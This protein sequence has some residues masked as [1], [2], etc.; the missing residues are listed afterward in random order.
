ME[1]LSCQSVVLTTNAAPMNELIKKEYGFFVEP[2]KQ[3]RMRL[4]LKNIISVESLEKA[5]INVSITE[6][7]ELLEM[8]KRG[9]EFFLKNDN[10][11]RIRFKQVIKD[12]LI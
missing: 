9:R 3:E 10:E 2:V 8:G 12:I 1:A 5:V 4:S 7:Q 11:F 6:E